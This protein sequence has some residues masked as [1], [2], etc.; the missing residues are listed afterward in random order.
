MIN[1]VPVVGEIFDAACLEREWSDV[2][3]MI[4]REDVENIH[5]SNPSVF[6]VPLN[7]KNKYQIH[8]HDDENSPKTILVKG[9]PKRLFAR[10]CSPSPKRASPGRDQQT[11]F[12][13]SGKGPKQ[14]WPLMPWLC[15]M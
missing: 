5:K 11:R 4:R 14:K 2:A 12:H 10:C 1:W 9:A 6:V 15:L 3:P 7:S 13:H 8:V